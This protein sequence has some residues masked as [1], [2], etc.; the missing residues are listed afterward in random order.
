MY[1]ANNYGYNPYGRYMSQ[2]MPSMSQMQPI[3]N[4][5]PSQNQIS[6]LNRPILNGKQVESIDVVKAMDIPLDGSVSYF[7]IADGSAI[8]SKQLQLDG[9][10]KTVIY[11]PITEK[12]KDTPTYATVDQVK[13]MLSEIDTDDLKEELKELRQELKELKKK[14]KEE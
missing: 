8:V 4:T 10:S 13:E 1:G 11:K 5:S 12:L 2:P 3:E 6:A 7:P 14:K 9:T